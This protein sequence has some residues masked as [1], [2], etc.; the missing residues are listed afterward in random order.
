MYNLFY[1]SCGKLVQEHRDC[2]EYALVEWGDI[3]LSEI[4]LFVR[5]FS[6]KNSKFGAET[7]RIGTY[8]MTL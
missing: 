5:K 8:P 2:F 7:D 3:G 1:M 6:F 4:F